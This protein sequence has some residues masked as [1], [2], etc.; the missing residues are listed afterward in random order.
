MLQV[1]L[2]L[3]FTCAVFNLGHIFASLMQN[4]LFW[5]K[6][7]LLWSHTDMKKN[8]LVLLQLTPD[9]L[10]PHLLESRANSNQNRFPRE[11]RLKN[12]FQCSAYNIDSCFIYQLC[13]FICFFFILNWKQKQISFLVQKI[14]AVESFEL[15]CHL[16]VRI[17]QSF[18]KCFSFAIIIRPLHTAVPSAVL[19]SMLMLSVFKCLLQ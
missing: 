5:H 9:N 11:K 3:T 13:A 10:N 16:L 1:K 14:M 7:K 8:S 15:F 6:I 19:A 12:T 17:G 2:C 4:I 18:F